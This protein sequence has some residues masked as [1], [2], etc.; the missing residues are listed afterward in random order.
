MVD[1]TNYPGNSRHGREAAAGPGKPEAEKKVEKVISGEAVVR[2]KPLRR[3]MLETFIGD[4]DDASSVGEYI[5]RDVLVPA[6]KETVTDMVQQGIEH[7]IY[8]E[9]RARSRSPR[10][11]SRGGGGMPGHVQYNQIMAPSRG[12]VLRDDARP[13]T[14]S[15]RGRATHDFNEILLATRVDAQEVLDQLYTLVS[16]YQAATVADLYTMIDQHTEFTDVKYG[17]TN[18]Q[19]SRIDHVKGGYLLVLPQPELLD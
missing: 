18:L 1:P 2:K 16:H 17:W 7:L 6:F 5:L 9:G 4:G 11:I 15:R 12:I 10:S 14:M 3:R 8:G 19:G 13:A